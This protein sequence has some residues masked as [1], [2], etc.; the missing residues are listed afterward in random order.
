M[1]EQRKLR[2][3]GARI[4]RVPDL[5]E[6]NEEGLMPSSLS[7]WPSSCRWNWSASQLHC[8]AVELLKRLPPRKITKAIL[9]GCRR[10]RGSAARVAA[11][12]EELGKWLKTQPADR[13]CGSPDRVDYV[14]LLNLKDHKAAQNV[15]PGPGASPNRSAGLGGLEA[16]PAY[17][18]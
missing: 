5:P 9:L 1:T 4:E 17:E 16:A 15:S 10:I 2:L 14:V 8:P 11:G 3:L 7:W 6:E 13:I 18:Q 12:G